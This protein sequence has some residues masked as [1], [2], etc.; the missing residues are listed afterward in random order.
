MGEILELRNSVIRRAAWK[1]SVLGVFWS[2]FSRIR[3]EYGEIQASRSK[4]CGNCVFAQNFNTRKLDAI[5]KNFCLKISYCH[6]PQNKIPFK[7]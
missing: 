1:M 5:A 2:V 7:K 3:T 6:G 4:L